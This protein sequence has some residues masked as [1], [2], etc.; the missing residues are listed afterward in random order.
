MLKIILLVT[1]SR[2][3]EP[4][5]LPAALNLVTAMFKAAMG[6]EPP[7]EKDGWHW[8]LLVEVLLGQFSRVFFVGAFAQTAL[9]ALFKR[10]TRPRTL[11]PVEGVIGM[12]ASA[13]I[14]MHD[15]ATL[16]VDN[17]RKDLER[18]IKST[19]PT[20]IPYN[21][22]RRITGDSDSDRKRKERESKRK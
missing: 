12:G 13:L 2:I 3:S 8:T 20:R 14:T 19:A 22:Y 1:T 7:W 21:L 17:L 15:L 10:E 18:A 16:N 9:E 5:C 6:D 11:L 4:V